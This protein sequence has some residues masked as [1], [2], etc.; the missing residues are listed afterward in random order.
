MALDTQLEGRKS[1]FPN[2][3]PF[4]TPDIQASSQFQGEFFLFVS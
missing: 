3:K 2:D 1:Y 4:I